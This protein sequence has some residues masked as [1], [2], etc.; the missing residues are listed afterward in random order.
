MKKKKRKIQ[1]ILEI[2]TSSISM[3]KFID[4]GRGFTSYPQETHNEWGRQNPD[5]HFP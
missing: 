3:F 2:M 4:Q 1:M 5:I